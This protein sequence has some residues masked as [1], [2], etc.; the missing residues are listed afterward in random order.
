MDHPLMKRDEKAPLGR[1]AAG[2]RDALE[3]AN[4]RVKPGYLF[5]VPWELDRPGGV[6]QVVINLFHQMRQRSAYEPAIM[7]SDWAYPKVEQCQVAGRPTLYYRLRSP[8]SKRALLT[9]ALKFLA[10]LPR[11]VLALRRA[12]AVHQ[13]RTINVHYPSL[14][15]LHIVGM[16]AVGAYHGRLIL[17]FH[18]LDLADARTTTGLERQLWGW[19]LRS[20]DA[21]VGCSNDM[22]RQ[23]AEF[24]PRCVGRVTAVQNGID[25]AYL[26][27]E[28]DRDFTLAPELWDTEY[29]LSTSNF[30]H[31]KGQDILIEAFHEVAK[32][33]PRLK[34][35]LIGR[36]S[37]FRRSL[38]AL[39]ARLGLTGRVLFHL[40]LPHAQ[41]CAF[42][43]R[44]C[45]FCLPSRVEPFGIAILEA[46]AFQVPVVASRVGGIPE[47]IDHDVS[48]RLV[49]P[50]DP[51]AL[52]QEF[53]RLLRDPSERSRLGANL[54][55]R[56]GEEFTWERAYSS[57]LSL[58]PA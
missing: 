49:P 3:P 17:S 54:Y 28:R 38:V 42:V 55:R 14:S 9:N 10:E 35:V 43:E 31:K 29:I 8:W 23:I 46:G 12:F 34:L 39:V 45:L 44:A 1:V 40:D 26:L 48:G 19:L 16:R 47:I 51:A 33:Y 21:L 37:E 25:L 13:V 5:V 24:E 41:I 32:D 18:G 27:H 7:I 57:Y 56:V 4:S 2:D 15:A 53:R 50:D 30:E 22:A 36:D 20:A 11:S 52:A 58:A 6:N